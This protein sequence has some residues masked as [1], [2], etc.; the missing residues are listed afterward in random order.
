VARARQDAFRLE[1]L[2]EADLQGFLELLSRM[3]EGTS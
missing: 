1:S 3:E 2:L